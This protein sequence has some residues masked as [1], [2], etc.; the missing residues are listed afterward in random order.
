MRAA[1]GRIV[2]LRRNA[3][4]RTRP[5]SVAPGYR[6]ALRGISKR[7][8]SPREWRAPARRI[9]AARRAW[10]RT[11]GPWAARPPSDRRVPLAAAPP[12]WSAAS[13]SGRPDPP[14]RYRCQ[15]E[16]RRG[17]YCAQFAV[18]Q[19]PLGLQ[20]QRA[21]EATVVRQNGV[22]AQ[23]L[24]QMVRH[25]LRQPAG[26]D[27]DQRGAILADQLGGAVVDLA[28][29]LVAGYRRRVRPSA[30]RRPVPWRV[31]AHVHL[32]TS[33]PRNAATSSRGLTVAERPMRCGLGGRSVP[34]GDRA[35]PASGQVR[36]AL[37]VRHRVNLVDDQGLHAAPASRGAWRPSA[38]CKA[39]R[40]W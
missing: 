1:S 15:F 35:A 25:A 37:I 16:R 9:P 34:P 29:H 36:A 19:T 18:F 14:S 4:R 26:I 12:R 8:S 7:S 20:A 11:A 30:P 13:R 10:W 5:P 38:E 24:G 33:S 32:R 28:P 22:F 31:L 27:E 17:H 40:A 3:S 21:R 39:I 23:P 2:R 6:S